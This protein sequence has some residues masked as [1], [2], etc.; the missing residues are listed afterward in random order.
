VFFNSPLKRITKLLLKNGS[1]VDSMNVVAIRTATLRPHITLG[2]DMYI[3]VSDR[4]LLY[5]KKTDNIEPER[6]DRL[7][8]KKVRSL[9]IQ[10]QDLP[11]YDEFLKHSAYLALED[12]KL[13]PSQ[14]AMI[15]SGQAKAVLEE[16][17]ESPQQKDLYFK[18]QAVAA[19][20]VTFLLK[21]PDALS[22]VLK[23]AAFDKTT[24]QHSVNVSALSIGLGAALGAP[25]DGCQILSIGGLLHDI[26][27]SQ[28]NTKIA[29]IPYERMDLD[30]KEQYIQHPRIG[31]GLLANK[32][33][34]SAD[35]LDVILLH[36]ER[37]DG[38]GFPAGVTKLDQ[39]FQVV[40][41][42]NLYDRKVTFL[43]K[44]PHEAY[45][46]I[47]KMNPPPYDERLI[48]GLKDILVSNKIY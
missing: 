24:Y 34:V 22:L 36:E 14:K 27:K 43:N 6:L 17:F 7:N 28:L 5:V 39:I 20:Q 23:I 2:F 3:H 40:G 11:A 26:G 31:A 29:D 42:A 9:F 25:P 30:Q 18:T 15:V 38:Q 32:K 47:R 8:K 13:A 48:Q 46:L 35:V 4:Y 41:L 33:Y 1:K 12:P 45:E 37:L 44:T 19:N 10:E 21:H 16:V